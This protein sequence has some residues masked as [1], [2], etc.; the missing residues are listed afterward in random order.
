LDLLRYTVYLA[1]WSIVLCVVG[2]CFVIIFMERDF[3]VT[4]MRLVLMAT[5]VG[6]AAQAW[7]ARRIS[8]NR[9]VLVSAGLLLAFVLIW[10]LGHLQFPYLA[11]PALLAEVAIVWGSAYAC[12]FLLLAMRQRR[13]PAALTY[14]GRIS[15][16]VYLL[17]LIP[18]AYF[19]GRVDHP[20]WQNMLGY[21]AISLVISVASYH[22]VEKPGI[23]LGRWVEKLFA[24]T[25]TPSL[26]QVHSGEPA[27]CDQ[28]A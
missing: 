3:P 26:P 19:I 10:C 20:L 8:L 24:A 7:S 27:A 28:L 1:L 18:L 21:L 6:L 9:L 23:K 14:L 11:S 13:M 5:V 2:V 22:L 4:S 16:S 12:F 25:V 17:H 15:Y